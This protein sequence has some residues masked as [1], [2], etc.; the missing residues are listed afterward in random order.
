MEKIKTEESVGKVL[1]A[2][3]TEI[4]PGIKK[5][6]LFKRGHII[7]KKDIDKLLSIGKHY[8]WVFGEDEGFIHEDDAAKE[9]M[10]MLSGENLRLGEPSE[11]KVKLFAEESGVLLIKSEGLRCVNE[12][13]DPRVTTKSH[14]SFV[15]KG[16]PVALGKVMP[17]E[18][19]T[20]ELEEIRRIAEEFYPIISLKVLKKNKVAIFPVGNEFIEGRRKETMS[21]KVKEYLESLGQEVVR[22]DI[23]PD[24][25]SKIA[26]SGEEAL[27]EGFDIVIYMGGISIDPD[28][29][30]ADGIRKIPGAKE[31][32]YG[33]PMWPGTTFLISYKNNKVILGIP[34]SSGLAKSGTSFHR[35]M[36][37]LL[38]GYKLSKNEILKMANG[39]FI[40]ATNL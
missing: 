29:R 33:V 28:D 39:G 6:P 5:G 25:E 21:F 12:L 14:F 38:T 36:P 13:D 32:I 11:S 35:I 9:M 23:L 30:T 4:I 40:D 24:D 20:T 2:D 15:R 31:V 3:V 8:I 18:I 1:G 37:I 7:E 27:K 17:V 34:S 22:R 10:K 26:E 19:P 16:Q